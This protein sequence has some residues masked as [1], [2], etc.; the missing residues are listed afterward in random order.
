[1]E[2]FVL[3]GLPP[4]QLQEVQHPLKTSGRPSK[5]MIAFEHQNLLF[6]EETHPHLELVY[7]GAPGKIGA[8][9]AL[10]TEVALITKRPLQLSLLPF[11]FSC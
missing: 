3:T 11:V 8:I 9:L 2:P 5:Q 10:D 4:W 7:T 6:T 1:M